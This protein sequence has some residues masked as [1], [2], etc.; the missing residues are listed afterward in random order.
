MISLSYAFS[1]LIRQ[2]CMGQGEMGC[3]SPVR[4]ILLQFGGKE[5][6]PDSGKGHEV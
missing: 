6:I 5:V 4:I 3:K 2:H 1:K